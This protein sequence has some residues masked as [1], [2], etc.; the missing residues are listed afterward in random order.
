[1]SWSVS[2]NGIAEPHDIMDAVGAQFKETYPE[3]AEG[4][5]DQARA[6]A[7]VAQDLAFEAFDGEG[8]FNVQMSGHVKNEDSD[9][10]V[11]VIVTKV[12]EAESDETADAPA[13]AATV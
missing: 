6:A 4:V 5:D 7:G 11:S 13:E 10:F 2:K 1:M 3:P 8:P 12:T 9:S